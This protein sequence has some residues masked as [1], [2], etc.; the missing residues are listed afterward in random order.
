P[1][2]YLHR[3]PGLALSAGV[4]A[5]GTV[6]MELLLKGKLL[7]H[8][9]TGSLAAGLLIGGLLGMIA[10]GVTAIG[11]FAGASIN[12]AEWE[13]MLVARI[14][15]ADA[16]FDSE[17]FLI[18]MS[19]AFL[20]PAAEAFVKRAWFQ[21]VLVFAIA[22]MTMAGLEPFTLRPPRR[23]LQARC[24]PGCPAGSNAVSVCW[25]GLAQ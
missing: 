5:R 7:R 17:Q 20:I 24:Q 12:A 13:N 15:S 3:A 4:P 11:V 14:P 22:F 23:R 21:R 6:D 2:L 9:V 25:R 18:F 1:L 19:F 10:H 8:P 16:L